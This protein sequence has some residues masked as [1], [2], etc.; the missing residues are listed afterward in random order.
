MTTESLEKQD[1]P[2]AEMLTSL[3]SFFSDTSLVSW[4]I[5]VTDFHVAPGA[6]WMNKGAHH[7][8]ASATYWYT[9]SHGTSY[10]VQQFQLILFELRR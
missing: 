8:L 6:R 5:T 9:N 1:A 10:D 7:A 3:I 4:L 2:S